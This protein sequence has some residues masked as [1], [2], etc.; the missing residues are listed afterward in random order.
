MVDNILNIS[1]YWEYTF[2]SFTTRGDVR[3]PYLYRGGTFHIRQLH[4]QVGTY[5]EMSGRQMWESVWRNGTDLVDTSVE[6]YDWSA[7]GTLF[8]RNS[9]FKVI[10][11]IDSYQGNRGESTHTFEVRD[12]KTRHIE[13]K[14]F[15]V[16][17]DKSMS[18]DSIIRRLYDKSDLYFAPKE[19]SDLIKGQYSDIVHG[20]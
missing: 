3:K 1:G 13:G 12:I 4:S 2:R 10:I 7:R 17:K 8:K 6:L 20:G 11:L 5:L 14:F 18:G 9:K 15:E 19:I 16:T